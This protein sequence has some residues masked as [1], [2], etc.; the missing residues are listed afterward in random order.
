MSSFVLRYDD[1]TNGTKTFFP[2]S[3]TAEGGGDA[4]L[5]S[6]LFSRYL[7]EL[8]FWLRILRYV[9]QFINKH[10]SDLKED[11]FGIYMYVRDA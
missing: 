9:T 2:K 8:P 7:A 3:R 5:K 1:Q 6:R 10:H 4:N 11:S